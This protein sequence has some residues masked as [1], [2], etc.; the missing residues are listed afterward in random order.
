MAALRQYDTPAGSSAS[1]TTITSSGTW[2]TG[3]LLIG[4]TVQV[5]LA[6]AGDV[7]INSVIDSAGQVYS[8]I[9]SFWDATDSSLYA[10]YA[11][12][13]NQ[14]A[15]EITV[16]ATFALTVVGRNI[17]VQELTATTSAPDTSNFPPRMSVSNGGI[18]SPGTQTNAISVALT[19]AG[20]SGLIT[21]VVAAVAGSGSLAAG[22]GFTAGPSFVA[23]AFFSAS[24]FES[25]VMTA[26]GPNNCTWTDATDG[27]SS[28]YLG[29]AT[30]WDSAVSTATIAWVT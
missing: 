9:G 22:T 2:T 15:T 25:K 6:I 30:I 19:S 29:M 27:A 21:G 8:K 17:H 13:N 11:F 4:S 16:T 14:S 24:L 18:V 7:T 20:S 5:W 1:S 3:A 10:C 12:Y 26:S 23:G 28:T